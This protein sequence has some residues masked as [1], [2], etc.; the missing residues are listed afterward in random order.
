MNFKIQIK[1]ILKCILFIDV[2]I[3]IKFKYLLV[4]YVFMLFLW[5][6]PPNLVLVF[7]SFWWRRKGHCL[8][9]KYI[10]H[11]F[12]QYR[13]LVK[14]WN[15]Q[16]RQKILP[17]FLWE[18]FE[19]AAIYI[20]STLW[21]SEYAVICSV[22]F[23][24]EAASFIKATAVILKDAVEIHLVQQRGCW[25]FPNFLCRIWQLLEGFF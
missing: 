14:C 8:Y 25:V 3:V 11:I 7:L 15:K 2:M 12:W 16:S 10:V 21:I 4:N 6:N 24:A 22:H 13:I 18:L 20:N 23:K 17:L 1:G 5:R 19:H 9:C